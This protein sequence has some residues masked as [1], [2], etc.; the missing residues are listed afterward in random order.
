M[1]KATSLVSVE[2]EPMLK[3]RYFLMKMVG[4]APGRVGPLKASTC[5]EGLPP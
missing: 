1:T 5:A 2:I 3:A 4:R